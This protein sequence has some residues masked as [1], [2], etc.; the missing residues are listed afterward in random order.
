MAS[1]EDDMAHT[2]CF[3]TPALLAG[4]NSGTGL[5]ENLKTGY[6]Q[7]GAGAFWLFEG[8]IDLSGFALQKKTFYPY[9][10]FEQRSTPTY[11]EFVPL[12]LQQPYS[13]DNMIISSVP[14]SDTDIGL[15][16]TQAPGF[17]SPNAGEMRYNRDVIMHSELKVYTQ[18]STIS[19][20]QENILALVSS[21]RSSSLEPSAADKLY[22]Y[23]VISCN[24]RDGEGVSLKFPA[25]RILI[26]GT[27]TSEPTLEYNM[28]L[29]RSYE[30]ANQV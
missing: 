26:P 15:S 20:G 29:K 5:W 17:I 23:R 3:E 9:S 24:A 11:G 6:R 4:Y 28:R 30:L 10:S 1:V 2:L 16:L 14:L 22:C 8:T 21:T 27:I 13:F 19:G 25:A 12:F 7:L 18:D